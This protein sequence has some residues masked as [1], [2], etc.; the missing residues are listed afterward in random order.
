MPYCPRCQTNYPD[1]TRVCWPCRSHLL[2]GRAEEPESNGAE[3]DGDVGWSKLVPVYRA[4]DELSALRIHSIL[5]EAGILARIQSGQ[6]P[7]IDGV[8]SNIQGYW[9]RVLVRPEEREAAEELVEAYV[10]SLRRGTAADEAG[11]EP[12]GGRT[13]PEPG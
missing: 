10:D 2:E 11:R 8:M 4:P 6:I 13:G 3:N 1:G 9:G 7:W 5:E 12:G